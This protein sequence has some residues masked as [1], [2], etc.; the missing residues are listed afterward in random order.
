MFWGPGP[1]KEFVGNSVSDLYSL[2]EKHFL[3]LNGG[4]LVPPSP[5]ASGVGTA[6]SLAY[7]A[8]EL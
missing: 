1:Q 6:N 5:S 4:H 8:Y 2:A 7:L 3:L